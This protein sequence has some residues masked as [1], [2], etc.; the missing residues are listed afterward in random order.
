VLKLK[1]PDGR[2]SNTVALSSSLNTGT[3]EKCER[4]L[5][6]FTGTLDSRWVRNSVMQETGRED[7]NKM[8]FWAHGMGSIMDCGKSK[9]V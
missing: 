8:W 3:W 4:D 2:Y 7:Q 6:Q 1:N 9:W 5:G